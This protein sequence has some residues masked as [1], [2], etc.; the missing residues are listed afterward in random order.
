[1]PLITQ[2]RDEEN[3]QQQ[4]L[5]DPNSTL[6]DFVDKFKITRPIPVVED[7]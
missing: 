3:Y 6:E 2:A 1:V 4:F 5:F 7:G